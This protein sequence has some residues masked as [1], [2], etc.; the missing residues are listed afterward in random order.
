MR[1]KKMKA[2]PQVVVVM[3]CGVGLTACGHR[4]HV[5][6]HAGSALPPMK[7]AL[8]EGHNNYRRGSLANE[9]IRIVEVDH[10]PVPRQW[11]VAEGANSVAVLPGSHLIKVLYVHGESTGIDYYAYQTIPLYAYENCTYRV[12]TYA[13]SKRG[14]EIQFGMAGAPTTQVGN[15]DCGEGIVEVEKPQAF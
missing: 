11:G 10:K 3:L 4:G 12:V 8:I 7:R 9:M 6:M 5:N 13:S 2:W 14:S 1:V 15:Q